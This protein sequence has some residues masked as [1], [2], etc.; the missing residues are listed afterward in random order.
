MDEQKIGFLEAYEKMQILICEISLIQIPFVAN[1]NLTHVYEHLNSFTD[2]YKY[3]WR[4]KERKP[5]AFFRYK[6]GVQSQ[7]KTCAKF[8]KRPNKWV[9]LTNSQALEKFKTVIVE[10]DKLEDVPIS[11]LENTN[12]IKSYFE[13][14]KP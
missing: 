11:V 12:S 10:I 7:C 5:M 8:V 9:K 6:G 4:C 2:N 3:C 14:Y 13:N 1:C